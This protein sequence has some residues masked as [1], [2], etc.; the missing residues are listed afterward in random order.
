MFRSMPG[1][2]SFTAFCNQLRVVNNT[3]DRLCDLHDAL[4]ARFTECRVEAVGCMAL[5]SAR[6][7][8]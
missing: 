5:F 8:S 7:P 4:C 1:G 3:N 2:V 6:Y